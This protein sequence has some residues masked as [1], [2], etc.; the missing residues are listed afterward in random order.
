MVCMAFPRV[1]FPFNNVANSCQK[2]SAASSNGSEIVN[3]KDRATIFADIANRSADI[4][5]Q[6]KYQLT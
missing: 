4:T 5:A 3:D 1:L 2:D 6:P